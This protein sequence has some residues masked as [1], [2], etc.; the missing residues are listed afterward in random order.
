VAGGPSWRHLVVRPRSQSSRTKQH[1]GPPGSWRAAGIAE[2]CP[3]TGA[4]DW[5][6]CG[7]PTRGGWRARRHRES[8]GRYRP[9]L[10]VNLGPASYRAK[11]ACWR[12]EEHSL[13]SA[14]RTGYCVTSSCMPTP[15][16]MSARRGPAVPGLGT[17][18][19]LVS[20]ALEQWG[21]LD[22]VVNNAGMISVADPGVGI[23]HR[24][25][26]GPGD[27][28]CCARPQ[29]DHGVPGHPGGA[30]SHDQARLG[31]ITM[32]ASVTDPVMAIREDV[33]YATAKAGVVGLTRA[34]AADTSR[35]PR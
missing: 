9:V 8:P 6:Q 16:G 11:S 23:R 12:H 4:A 29:P 18:S 34:A 2:P 5:Q 26:H 31:R 32:V 14:A 19:G 20:A 22:I 24:G 28:A 25:I 1:R 7:S 33:G 21:R 35:T 27:L 17:A 30:A 15:D 13:S 3:W 10:A